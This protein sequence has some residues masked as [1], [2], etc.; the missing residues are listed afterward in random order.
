LLVAEEHDIVFYDGG[1]GLCHRLVRFILK[2]DRDGYFRFATLDSELFR[3][4]V[5]AEVRT[6]LPDSVILL[7][8]DGRVLSR[9]ASTREILRRLPARWRLVGVMLAIVPRP[10]ADWGYDAI[11]RSRHRLFK[12][13]DGAC[14]IVPPELRSR[15][16]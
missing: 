4:R 14:P 2:R 12:K 6:E 1:C 8:S 13:P 10:I 16:L 7:T 3:S 9:S 5:P 11:A 15:F